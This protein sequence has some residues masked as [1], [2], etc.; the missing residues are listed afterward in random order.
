MKKS[1]SLIRE[2]VAAHQVALEK[3]VQLVAFNYL[4]P[5]RRC[6]PEELFTHP[7]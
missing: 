6:S 4:R 3:F 2:R 5:Q 1:G 7:Q